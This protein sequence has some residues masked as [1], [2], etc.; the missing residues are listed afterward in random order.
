MES[1]KQSE[2]V[3][4]RYP[5]TTIGIVRSRDAFLR[6]LP[7]LLANP[8]FDRWLA[9]YC[10]DQRIAFAETHAEIVRQCQG[11]DLKED[12]YYL[13]CVAPHGEDDEEIDF[14]FCEF[15]EDDIEDA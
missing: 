8:K 1:I 2:A 10:G 11:R 13:G 7:T 9:V 15:D 12:E 5:N 3:D 6:D 4:P 14:G